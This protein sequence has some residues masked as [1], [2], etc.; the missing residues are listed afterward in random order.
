MLVRTRRD[1]YGVSDRPTVN[2]RTAVAAPAFDFSGKVVA[3][4]AILADQADAHSPL[5]RL[6]TF[7]G[8][9][10]R[11]LGHRMP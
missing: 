4:L 8:E 9:I 7:A 2:G 10:S 5:E 11:R 3:S 1:G 6:M